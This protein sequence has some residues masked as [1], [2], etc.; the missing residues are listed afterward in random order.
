MSKMYSPE[1]LDSLIEEALAAEPVR[2]APLGLQRR[3]DARVRVE[4]VVMRQRRLTARRAMVMAGATVALGAG[5]VLGVR[6]L[7][8]VSRGLSAMPGMMGYFDYL[9]SLYLYTPAQGTL[10]LTLA[11][12][13]GLGLMLLS[14]VAWW[15]ATQ[16][17]RYGH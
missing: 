4:A 15:G 10:T 13:A 6:A 3:I 7:D 12:A 2:P 1:E 5:G 9:R 8:L 17:R 14:G 11:T 16:S